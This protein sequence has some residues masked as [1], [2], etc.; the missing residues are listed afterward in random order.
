MPGPRSPPTHE[1]KNLGLLVSEGGWG[2]YS[3]SATGIEK[4]SAIMQQAAV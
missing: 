4:A 3:V 2:K 1:L